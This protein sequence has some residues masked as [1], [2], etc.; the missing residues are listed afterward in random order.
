MKTN[1]GIKRPN[2]FSARPIL[3]K[4][5]RMIFIE[6]KRTLPWPGQTFVLRL[7]EPTPKDA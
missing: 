7:V 3:G 6:I 2:D 4:E 5:D 1:T